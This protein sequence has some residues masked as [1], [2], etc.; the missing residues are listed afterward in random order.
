[1]GAFTVG[2]VLTAALLNAATADTGDVKSTSRRTAPTGWLL[3]D[4][5][6]VS[7]STYSDLFAVLCENIGTFTVTLASPGVFT[8]SSHGLAVGDRVYLTTTGALPTG[9]AANTIYY[10]VTVPTS[11]TFT[12]SASEGGAA[13]NTSG[14]Q[15]GTHTL[16]WCPWGLGDGSTTFNTPD[17]RGRVVVGASGSAG[18]AAVRALGQNDGVAVGNRRPHHRHTPHSH[19][20]KTD[21][22]SEGTGA[23]RAYP[24]AAGPNTTSNGNTTDGGSG[25]ATD[26]LDAPAYGVVNWVVKT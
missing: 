23:G 7:R 25:T 19:T 15:S 2:Q 21:N 18:P 5:T 3:C 10:V 6:A 12:V 11:S 1:M 4:G 14:S 9:L 22:L 20:Q 13:I 24:T 16:R 26:S 17:L 8:L